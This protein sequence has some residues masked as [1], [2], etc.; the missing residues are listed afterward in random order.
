MSTL[1]D[2]VRVERDSTWEVTVNPTDI[3]RQGDRR[4]SARQ[5]VIGVAT[6]LVVGAL[7]FF[8]WQTFGPKG[9]PLPAGQGTTITSA[10]VPP[11]STGAG[12]TRLSQAQADRV[13]ESLIGLSSEYPKGFSG[14]IQSPETGQMV[15]RWVGTPPQK[16][17][18]LVA[19]W[20]TKGVQITIEPAT[21]SVADQ[22]AAILVLERKLG[23]PKPEM[24]TIG[25]SMDGSGIE[26]ARP[27]LL[28]ASL[29][30]ERADAEEKRVIKAVN[31]TGK[32]TGVPFTFGEGPL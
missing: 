10:S 19:E 14:I 27:G 5:G 18:G 7:A 25:I 16:L 15:V 9:D 30:P 13:D 11:S 3:R 32:E 12:P 20:Q 26:V 24:L 17:L 23:K 2:L 31:E 6:V 8:G 21:V 22:D 4:K 28:E 1:E 29:F